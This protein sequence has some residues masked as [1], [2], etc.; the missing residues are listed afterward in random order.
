MKH[1]VLYSHGFG[2]DKTD[3]GLFTVIA[4]AIP[5][6]EH[7]M[8][9]YDAKDKDDNTIVETF[10]NRKSKLIAKY[11]ELRRQ[12]PDAIID[13][14]CHSQGCLVAALA[15][16]KNIRKV[17]ML[18][19]PIYHE[20]GD[21]KR[22]KYLSKPTV[23]D[24]PDKTLAVR[25]RDG[26]TTLIKQNYWNDFGVVTNSERLYNTLS[27]VTELIAIR[28]TEDEILQNN[29]YD[30]FDKS[31]RTMD[32]EGNH[33]FDNEARPRIAKVVREIIMAGM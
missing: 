15:K 28:A 32:V 8:F 18:T 27:E 11:E 31:I 14:I 21:E 19:P 23:K 12:N 1:I 26:S 30:D 25:R 10:S 5:E 22:E 33:S 29:S 2:V 17:I 6:A 7:I 13:L 3:R 20:D 4:E 16:L 24:L 9:E